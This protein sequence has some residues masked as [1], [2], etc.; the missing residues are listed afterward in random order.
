MLVALMNRLVLAIVFFSAV[1]ACAEPGL[2]IPTETTLSFQT[3]TLLPGKITKIDLPDT[4][5]NRSGHIEIFVKINRKVSMLPSR[6]KA[7]SYVLFDREEI[8]KFDV[9]IFT[10]QGRALRAR[11]TDQEHFNKLEN[12]H[13]DNQII[14]IADLVLGDKEFVNAAGFTCDKK[15]TILKAAW[16][17]RFLKIE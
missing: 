10:N 16:F 1:L 2:L 11:T 4:I 7:G 3:L 8:A 5:E 14:F 6:D 13:I 15:I 9:V 17:D 12:P